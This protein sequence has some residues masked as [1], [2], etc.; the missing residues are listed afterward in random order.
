METKKRGRRPLPEERILAEAREVMGEM[1]TYGYRRIWARIR[2]RYRE[3]QEQPPNHKRVYRILKAH[4]LLLRRDGTPGEERAHD[5]KVAVDQSD[6]RWCSDEFHIPCD[7]QEQVHVLFSLDCCDREAISYLATTAGIA[8]EHVQDLMVESVEQRFDELTLC[9]DVEWLSDNGPPFAAR[10][11][12]KFGKQLGLRPC[13]TPIRSPQSNGM[14]EA[15]V[16]TIKRDYVAVNP[17]PDAR[18][19]LQ[20]LPQWFEHYNEHHPHRAL[21]YLSPREFRRAKLAHTP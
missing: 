7:N 21:G 9:D 5:G 14:A 4:G 18:T 15:F 2:S 20:K 12:R 13:R 17:R 1:P 3:R 19:V 11:T 10:I 8:S 6:R 16:K